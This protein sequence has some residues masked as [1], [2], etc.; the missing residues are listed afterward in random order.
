MK[1]DVQ[2]EAV[3]HRPRSVVS[4]FA[5]DPANAPRWYSNIESIEWKTP[6]PVGVGTQLVFRARFLGRKLQ[7]TYEV[8]AFTPGDVLVMK[9]AEGPFE[10]ETTY[11]W[12][13]AGDR[14]TRMTL[15]NRGEPRGFAGI[16]APVM[17]AAIRRANLKDLDRLKQILEG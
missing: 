7:Y 9:T 5:A 14:K 17:S 2:T 8:T 13:D 12:S 6:P 1:V 10:M 11:T 15:R 3:V 4:N 16:A